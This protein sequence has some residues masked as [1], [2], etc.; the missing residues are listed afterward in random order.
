MPCGGC[1]KQPTHPHATAGWGRHGQLGNGK[2]VDSPVPVEPAAER[3]FKA[4]S[5]GVGHTCGLDQLGRALCWGELGAHP[6][7]LHNLAPSQRSCFEYNMRT[8]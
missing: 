3:T 5:A 8:K 6:S 4:L 1:C 2:K 7:V